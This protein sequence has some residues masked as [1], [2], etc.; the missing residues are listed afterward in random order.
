LDI[1]FDPDEERSE[2]I[3]EERTVCFTRN[4][5]GGELDLSEYI[6]LRKV[7]IRNTE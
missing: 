7:S 3:R 1:I 4:L 5:E 6:N 2:N